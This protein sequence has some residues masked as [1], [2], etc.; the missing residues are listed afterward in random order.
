MRRLYLRFNPMLAIR[1]PHAQYR[2]LA[3]LATAA[4]F[5]LLT[6][7]W[8][9][10]TPDSDSPICTTERRYVTWVGGGRI[11]NLMFSTASLLGIA[12]QN[13]MTAL[14]ASDSPLRD[15]FDVSIQPGDVH[16]IPDMACIEDY[17]EFG[18]RASAYDIK[19]QHL[20][21]QK[22]YALQGYFQSWRYFN[23]IQPE[24]HKLFQFRPDIK[25]QAYNFHKAIHQRT[26][27]VVRV[28]IHVR[29]GDMK[30]EEKIKYGYVTAP[31]EYFRKA[32]KYYKDKFSGKVLFVICG[33]DTTWNRDTFGDLPNAVFCPGK[34][35]AL[36][37]AI[38]VQCEHSI[39]SV[40]SFG[41]WSAWLANGTTVYYS[42]WPR[43]YSV[44]EYMIDKMQYFP[45]HWIP[46]E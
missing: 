44:L 12:R 45:P 23:D 27:K 3:F 42:N 30:D 46:M 28:G 36:D 35:P 1:G 43:P 39:L 2:W 33:D 9:S 7:I 6:Y 5:A 29:R 8:T 25:S 15:M 26:E 41:W 16:H 4:I 34:K 20:D 40:G 24:I 13:N 19:T 11:G 31:V 22:S 32:M 21:L 18:R 17:E 38:L 14:L 37:M 10:A